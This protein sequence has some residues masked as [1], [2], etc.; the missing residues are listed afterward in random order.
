LEKLVG[1][2]SLTASLLF[3]LGYNIRQWRPVP[4]PPLAVVER[5]CRS[6]AV[7]SSENDTIIL[8]LSEPLSITDPTLLSHCFSMDTSWQHR[9]ISYHAGT[10]NLTVLSNTTIAVSF[11]LPFVD[12]YNAT[13]NCGLPNETIIREL[14]IELHLS[15]FVPSEEF[16]QMRCH[17]SDSFEDRWCECRN[18]AYFDE[19]FHFFSP[20]DFDFPFPFLLPGARRPPF[21]IEQDRLWH[22]PLVIQSPI[23]EFGRP[24]VII[25][26]PSYV[27]GL[28]HNAMMLW[29]ALFDVIVP[30]W[31][32][33]RIRN[34]SE[35]WR[36]RLVYL[37][38]AAFVFNDLARV[39]SPARFLR[40]HEEASF[41][42]E[43][44]VLGIEK[45]GTNRAESD[46]YRDSILFEYEVNQSTIAG[47]RE[48]VL[49]NFSIDP[50]ASNADDPP[51]ALL[52]DRGSHPRSITNTEAMAKVMQLG[53][54]RCKVELVSLHTM[55]LQEQLRIVSRASVL[56]G[57]HGSG[58]ANVVWMAK[59]RP[60]RP[61]HLVE[62][63][64]YGYVCRNW[65]ETAAKAAGVNYHFLM[66]ANPP[67]TSKP[68]LASCWEDAE[69][70]PTLD[71]HDALRDQSVTAELD[72]FSAVWSKIIDGFPAA[73]TRVSGQSE[74]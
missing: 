28:F 69:R 60:D 66:N 6:I 8:S 9:R 17:N 22:E 63:L 64:P 27:Y 23:S 65:Y 4:N 34:A 30:F 58:L 68:E 37:R 11:Y 45:L 74:V 14:P 47:L 73:A 67:N 15:D 42:F 62:I 57:L 49:E 38:G 18:I 31:N 20:T 59:S 21:D 35:N 41:L 50:G 13:L 43:S 61:T 10:A 29:H 53:C 12:G 44:V 5:L 32:F 72:T 26:P 71:C 48:A 7:S 55:A 3:V 33:L 39:F 46:S 24:V 52:I 36:D 54:P 16:S 51:L 19:Q 70:C 56:V 40:L 2:L 1:V 25:S